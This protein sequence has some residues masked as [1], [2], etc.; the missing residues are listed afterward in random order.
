[1]LRRE[2]AVALQPVC[3]VEHANPLDDAS[4]ITRR[5]APVADGACGFAWVTVRPANSSFA[6]WLLSSHFAKVGY[7]GGAVIWISDYNQSMTRKE[8][9]AE[10]MA[11]YLRKVGIKAHAGSRMD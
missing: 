2:S 10:A 4:S 5:Y 8:S 6:K 1:M 9:H 11:A 7:D 3:V